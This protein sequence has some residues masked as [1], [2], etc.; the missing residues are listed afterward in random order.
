MHRCEDKMATLNWFLVANTALTFCAGIWYIFNNQLL[1]GLLQLV[2]TLSNI[3]LLAHCPQ[4][5]K[6]NS[7]TPTRQSIPIK[8]YVL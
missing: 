4:R 3:I 6:I 5:L 7:H 1:L 2:F 8:K